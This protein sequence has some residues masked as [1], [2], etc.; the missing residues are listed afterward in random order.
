MSAPTSAFERCLV[1]THC[2][3]DATEFGPD[4]DQLVVRARQAAVGAIVVPGISREN[5]DAV[6][7]IC[8]RY[9][10]CRPAYGIHPLFVD[11]ANDADLDLVRERCKSAEVVAVGEIGLDFYHDNYDAERQAFYFSEQ[12]KIGRDLDLPVI[13]HVRKAIDQ[14]LKHLR[15]IEVPG[16]IA[17]AFNGS[18]QQA[19]ILIGMGF[20][21]GFGG[22]MTW[23][24]AR[25]IRELAKAL[26]LDAIVLETDAPDIPPEWVG[27]GRNEPA[28]LRR[29]AEVLAEIRGVSLNE[30]TIS[31][32]KNARDALPR[33][34][35]VTLQE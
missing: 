13:L 29:I 34:A 9:G 30:I 21:L 4:R 24:R 11:Q 16:G 1:D 23:E 2:H 17:H 19:E 25:H 32:T 28:E 26:P 22:A 20:K 27:K 8:M 3:L 15:R 31:T 6:A 5:F 18:R 7:G 10:L 12:L 14:V 35:P 33:I